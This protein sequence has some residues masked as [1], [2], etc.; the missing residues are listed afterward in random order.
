M[1]AQ[2]T[3]IT[4]AIGGSGGGARQHLQMLRAALAEGWEL[5]QP[6]FARPQWTALDDRETALHF[7]LQREHTTQL[8]TVPETRAVQRFV[9]TQ[10]WRVQRP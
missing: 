9:R 2:L 10:A 7:V 6:I 8:L 4:P 3:H 1:T 5:V